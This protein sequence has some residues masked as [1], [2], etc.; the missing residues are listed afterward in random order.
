MKSTYSVL[1]SVN[2]ERNRTVTKSF[3]IN[4]KTRQARSQ[5]NLKQ[6]EIVATTRNLTCKKKFFPTFF[7]SFVPCL[8]VRQ[9]QQ[10]HAS[11]PSRSSASPVTAW[12]SRR[13]LRPWSDAAVE[14]A[15]SQNV[16]CD[17]HAGVSAIGARS[18]AGDC[19]RGAA[20]GQTYI[21]FPRLS[22]RL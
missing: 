11:F 6:K 9:H 7:Y 22:A 17:A 3:A 8:P 2:V 20:A 5:V 1:N 15:N 19:S 10:V 21:L 13:P 18:L 16:D 14:A 4:R 12:T